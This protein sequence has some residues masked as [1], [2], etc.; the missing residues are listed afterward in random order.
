M[1]GR[2]LLVA[3]M[4]THG[5]VHDYKV[6]LKAIADA[7]D[8]P[9]SLCALGVGDGPFFTIR[10]MAARED[11]G[12]FKNFNFINFTEFE[13]QFEKSENPEVSLASTIF[14]ELPK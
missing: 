10:S 6:D 4:I 2:Q 7:S 9:I 8:Y 1:G 5:I 11:T 13:K 12:R 14:S 3:V